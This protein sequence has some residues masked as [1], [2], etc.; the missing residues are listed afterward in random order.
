M[1]K[2]KKWK[3]QPITLS[4]NDKWIMRIIQHVHL[5][6]KDE[7]SPFILWY[8]ILI[9]PLNHSTFTNFPV[10]FLA[11]FFFLI[12]GYVEIIAKVFA[13]IYFRMITFVLFFIIFLFFLFCFV[14]FCF[15]L[16][17]QVVKI[18]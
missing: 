4:I 13:P 11:R 9:V 18:Y 10:I 6:R 8:N 15:I 17:M 3:N 16:T 14:F 5:H 1:E 7:A 12:H 2:N